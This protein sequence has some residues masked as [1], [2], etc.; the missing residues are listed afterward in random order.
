MTTNDRN[1]LIS[2]SQQLLI[3]E[4]LIQIEGGSSTFCKNRGF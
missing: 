2:E 3:K 4:I 1:K